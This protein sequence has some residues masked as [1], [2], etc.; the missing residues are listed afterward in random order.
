MLLAYRDIE[1]GLHEK[2]ETS[3]HHIMARSLTPGGKPRKFINQGVLTPRMLDIYHNTG[4]EALHN[5]VILLR[6]PPLFVINS[7]QSVINDLSPGN[8][9]DQLIEF[10]DTVDYMSTH[11]ASA[12]VRKECGR[13]AE[14]MEQQMP[15]ILRGQVELVRTLDQI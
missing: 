11:N 13:L 7:L 8:R 10:V 3:I 6:P 2:K 15:Y 9:Y 4:D 5:N 14:N 1:G 12:P